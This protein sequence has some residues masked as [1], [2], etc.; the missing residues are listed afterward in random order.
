MEKI[1]ELVEENQ[2]TLFPIH[3]QKTGIDK[4][5][6][7][8]NDITNRV[9]LNVFYTDQVRVESKQAILTKAEQDKLSR[10]TRRLTTLI[11]RKLAKEQ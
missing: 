10:H 2:Y 7:S 11:M 6:L 3:G 4:I 8:I 1:R 5:T 9:D